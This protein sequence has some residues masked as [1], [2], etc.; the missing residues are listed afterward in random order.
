MRVLLADNHIV[1][2]GGLRALLEMYGQF[3]ICGEADNGAAAVELAIR[4]KP[5][6]VVININLPD[7]NGIEVTRQI[8]KERPDTEVLIFTGENNEELMREALCAGARGYLLKS[9]SDEQIIRA[10][11]ALGQ[12]RTF[13]SSAVSEMLLDDLARRTPGIR[14]L[15]IN[16]GR[17]L[18]DRERQTLRLI[19]AGHRTKGIAQMLGISPKT[20]STHRAAAMRKLHLQ[21]TADI[22]RYAMREGIA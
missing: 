14:T 19:A 22:V 1:I 8:R 5:D 15:G 12:H 4:K 10:I 11:E 21:S 9:A 16:E 2:R 20:V 3:H 18:T 17:R 13:C 7:I 6:V